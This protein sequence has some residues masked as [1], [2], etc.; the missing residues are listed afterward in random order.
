MSEGTR[1]PLAEAQALAERLVSEL[2]DVCEQITTAGSIRRQKAT[3]GDLE[4]VCVPKIEIVMGGLF[5]DQPEE[6]DLLEAR[7][8]EMWEDGVI[9]PRI[10][11]NGRRAVGKRYRRLLYHDVALDLFSPS[12]E[13][14]GAILAI[15]TG[16]AEYSHL[17]V[18]PRSQRGLMPDHLRMQE[19]AL[20]YRVSGEVIPTP[21]EESFF[22]ALGLPFLDPPARS[23]AAVR[24]AAG[25]T[26]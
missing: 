1:M 16:P 8:W 26:P 22:A 15:R 17:F 14:Y 25:A 10:D 19:G 13:S 24:A 20:R 3:V 2:Q 5:E 11:K 23:L 21:T 7:I 9:K 12:A 4:I 18:T 6:A